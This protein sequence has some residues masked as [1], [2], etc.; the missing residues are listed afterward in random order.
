MNLVRIEPQ[1]EL[2]FGTTGNWFFDGKTYIS[3]EYMLDHL[4]HNVYG[5]ELHNSI[6]FEQAVPV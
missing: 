2:I 5:A 6:V 1:P 4:Y 3:N